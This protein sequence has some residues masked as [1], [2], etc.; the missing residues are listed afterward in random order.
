MSLKS[1]PARICE[2]LRASWLAKRAPARLL[3]RGRASRSS[4][5][6]AILAQA[7]SKVYASQGLAAAEGA[8]GRRPVELLQHQGVGPKHLLERP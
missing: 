1:D 4:D 7:L 3:R 5:G 8:G 6:A 2:H